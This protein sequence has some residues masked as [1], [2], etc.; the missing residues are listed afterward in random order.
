MEFSSNI[1]PISFCNLGNIANSPAIVKRG[2]VRL[3]VYGRL[4]KN[5]KQG[6]RAFLGSRVSCE[7]E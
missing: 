4:S 2:S 6:I 7:V 3:P 5:A 1:V